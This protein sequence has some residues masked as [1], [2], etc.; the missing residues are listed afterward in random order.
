MLYHA[1]NFIIIRGKLFGAP[2]IYINI[3]KKLI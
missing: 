3:L 1:I 2:L